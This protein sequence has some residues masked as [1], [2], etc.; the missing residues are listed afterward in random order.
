MLKKIFCSLNGLI[1][2]VQIFPLMAVMLLCSGCFDFN[3]LSYQS[4]VELIPQHRGYRARGFKP[5]YYTNFS[6]E[7]GTEKTGPF[8]IQWDPALKSYRLSSGSGK[9]YTET[10]FQLLPLR[11]DYYLLQSGNEDYY[12]YAIIYLRHDIV[13][14]LNCRENQYQKINKLIQ[15][16]GLTLSSKGEL[17]GSKKAL[18]S[19]F[20]TLVRHRLLQSGEQIKR[21]EKPSTF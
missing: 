15:K 12:V 19:F 13:D 21:L 1:P 7:K 8:K 20:K 11:D 10:S 14:F 4:P 2:T 16:K 18:K 5:G 17:S 6:K 9:N 3:I